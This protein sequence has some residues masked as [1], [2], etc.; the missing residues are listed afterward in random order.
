MNVSVKEL[1]LSQLVTGLEGYYA[2]FPF[3]SMVAAHER[4][5]D[6]MKFNRT[7]RDK[8]REKG[9]EDEQNLKCNSNFC[10]T[11]KG[12]FVFKD[13]SEKCLQTQKLYDINLLKQKLGLDLWSSAISHVTCIRKINASN[14]LKIILK[15]SL[16]LLFTINMIFMARYTNKKLHNGILYQIMVQYTS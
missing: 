16:S 14:H 5:K 4:S 10:L 1:W 2:N 12:I 6:I 8:G 3:Q 7:N 9:S 15:V 13:H 11:R